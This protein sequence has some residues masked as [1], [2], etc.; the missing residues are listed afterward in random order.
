VTSAPSIVERG[1]FL[2]FESF[3]ELRRGIGGGAEGGSL[4][5]LSNICGAERKRKLGRGSAHLVVGGKVQP[6]CSIKRI[7][8]RNL[9]EGRGS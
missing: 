6:P 4:Y 5:R 3:L 7:K 8:Q 2:R 1:D 9:E